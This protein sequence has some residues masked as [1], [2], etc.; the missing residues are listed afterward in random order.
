MEGNFRIVNGQTGAVVASD[1]VRLNKKVKNQ[2]DPTQLITSLMDQ[3]VT[4][5][6]GKVVEN[7]YPISSSLVFPSH[8]ESVER[9]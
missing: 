5:I 2:Q 4:Q 1:K 8:L 6:V 3:F 7:I 9:K